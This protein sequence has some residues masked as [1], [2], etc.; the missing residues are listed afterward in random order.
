MVK[1]SVINNSEKA[2]EIIP[3]FRVFN[4]QNKVNTAS[5]SNHH[6]FHKAMEKFSRS[7]WTL[8]VPD[9]GRL[10]GIMNGYWDNIKCYQSCKTK[11]ERTEFEIQSKKA[12]VQ[13]C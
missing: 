3:K 11:S 9:K 2:L 5:F 7:I 4:T 1:L 13:D 12:D 6:E 10:I 8:S